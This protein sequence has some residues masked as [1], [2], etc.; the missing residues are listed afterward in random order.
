MVEKVS[1]ERLEKYLHEHI[2][3]P[4][5]MADASLNVSHRNASG[6]WRC[7]R[8][9]PKSQTEHTA[10]ALALKADVQLALLASFRLPCIQLT[11][12]D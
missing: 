5:G 6:F 10:S 4:L 7:L 9:S 8:V 1:G 3:G 12:G 2:F 11:C